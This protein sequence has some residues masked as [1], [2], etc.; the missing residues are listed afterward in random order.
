MK[1]QVRVLQEILSN[2]SVTETRHFIEILS[3]TQLPTQS[4]PPTADWRDQ[5]PVRAGA[6]LAG[7]PNGERVPGE[8]RERYLDEAVAGPARRRRTDAL[9]EGDLRPVTDPLV[10]RHARAGHVGVAGG[11][12]VVRVDLHRDVARVR[13]LHIQSADT[14]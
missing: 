1:E 14:S 8:S 7:E 10:A 13:E 11:R 4:S 2:L 5:L 3:R 6:F 9:F 12:A